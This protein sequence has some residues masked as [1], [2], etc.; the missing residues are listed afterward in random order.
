APPLLLRRSLLRSRSAGCQ[1]HKNKLCP[2]T[3]RASSA[4]RRTGRS[5]ARC[6]I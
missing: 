5:T 1:R 2:R 3:R 4:G 6:K